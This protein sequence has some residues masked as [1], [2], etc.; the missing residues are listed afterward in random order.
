MCFCV[1]VMRGQ[2]TEEDVEAQWCHRGTTCPWCHYCSES[3]L[4][5]CRALCLGVG[6]CAAA[7]HSFS[8][9]THTCIILCEPGLEGGPGTKFWCSGKSGRLTMPG[10]ESWSK[11]LLSWN[12]QKTMSGICHTFW[13]VAKHK[14]NSGSGFCC[15]PSGI[16]H[17]WDPLSLGRS[18]CFSL[19]LCS[20]PGLTSDGNSAS[21]SYLFTLLV[22]WGRNLK[23]KGEKNLCVEIKMV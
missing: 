15:L 22:G 16:H 6:F 1:L 9:D 19:C 8:K 7:V 3:C 23:S 4:K 2:C 18:Q 20:C 10:K 13:H 11:I 12:T 5:K 21:Y 14:A 17:V